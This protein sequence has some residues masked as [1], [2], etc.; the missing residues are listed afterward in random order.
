MSQQ[1]FQQWASQLHEPAQLP[2]HGGEPAAARDKIYTRPQS[3][4]AM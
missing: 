3:G 4:C 1:M 2:V